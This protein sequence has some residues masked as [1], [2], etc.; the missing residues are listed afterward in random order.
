MRI[1]NM[2]FQI[3]ILGIQFNL[4]LF[5]Y[6][7]GKEI[8][9]E[10]LIPLWLGIFIGDFKVLVIDTSYIISWRR[11]RPYIAIFNVELTGR[12]MQSMPSKA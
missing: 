4:W 7:K 9:Y 12:Q 11:F 5:H 10:Y 2:I 6:W 1:E 3:S 8:S